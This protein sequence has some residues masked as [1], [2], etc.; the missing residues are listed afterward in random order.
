MYMNEKCTC[1]YVCT[2]PCLVHCTRSLCVSVCLLSPNLISAAP[3]MTCHKT[4]NNFKDEN[5]I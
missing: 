2:Y 3:L 1:V 5:L 4:Y